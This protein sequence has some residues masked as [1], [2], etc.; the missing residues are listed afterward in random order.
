MKVLLTRDV[1]KLG[2]AGTVTT[3]ADGYARNYL[4]PKGLALPATESA[5]KQADSFRAVEAKRVDKLH[6]E[7]TAL[8]ER[9]AGVSVSFKARAG[10][11]DKL[12]GSITSADIAAALAEEIGVEIDKR[13]IELG[14]P[15]RELGTHQVTVRLAAELTPQVTVIVEREE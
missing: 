11:K 8:A 14:E 15:L 9:L 13:K 5:L 6:Q 4:I 7:A 10:E 3:V 12:Y 1:D 2:R